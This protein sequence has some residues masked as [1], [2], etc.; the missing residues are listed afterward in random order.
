[1]Y[2]EIGQPGDRRRTSTGRRRNRAGPQVNRTQ[3]RGREVTM[4]TKMNALLLCLSGIS[5]LTLTTTEALSQRGGRGGG[6]G[7]RSAGHAAPSR[8]QARQ[9]GTRNDQT[10]RQCRT[11]SWQ[12]R[13]K[14]THRQTESWT[15]QSCQAGRWHTGNHQTERQKSRWWAAPECRRWWCQAERRFQASDCREPRIAEVKW[16]RATHQAR[17]IRQ[18]L[19]ANVPVFPAKQIGR[20]SLRDREADRL[21]LS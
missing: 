14:T 13:R 10:E 4:S 5:A 7:G 21:H 19:V 12:R 11:G 9:C 2:L 3:S 1:M 16:R 8:T 20:I 6:S 15:T 17:P 18:R